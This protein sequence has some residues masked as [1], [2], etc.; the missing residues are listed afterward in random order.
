MSHKKLMFFEGVA[1][2]KNVAGATAIA[3]A[4]RVTLG[5]RSKR[6]PI[7]KRW[8]APL[9]RTYGITIANRQGRS[10]GARDAVSVAGVLTLTDATM[11]M[12]R[13]PR[14]RRRRDGR[15]KNST[16]ASAPRSAADATDRG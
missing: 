16:R 11:P 14:S 13:N 3:D 8:G 9:I 12:F 7:E 2:E 1:R 4:V 5:P 10:P 15:L 6:V